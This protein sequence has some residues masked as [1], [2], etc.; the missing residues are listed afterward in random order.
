M[1]E[2]KED[3]KG[4]FQNGDKRNRHKRKDYIALILYFS[5]I[6]MV[7]MHLVPPVLQSKGIF[8]PRNPQ[9]Q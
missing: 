1:E 6:R 8:T 4:L 5:L 7:F 2:K 9:A 3:K